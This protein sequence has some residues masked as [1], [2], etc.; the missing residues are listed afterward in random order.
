[1]TLKLRELP[2]HAAPPVL[3]FFN[4]NSTLTHAPNSSPAASHGYRYPDPALALGVGDTSLWRATLYRLQW[5]YLKPWIQEHVMSQT[6]AVTNKEWK[7]V[8]AAALPS[9]GEGTFTA[10][11]RLKIL[12]RLVPNIDDLNSLIVPLPTEDASNLPAPTREETW[13]MSWELS[14]LNF[15]MDLYVLDQKLCLPPPS[16]PTSTKGEQ[17]AE[18]MQWQV[19]RRNAVLSCF[20]EPTFFPVSPLKARYGLASENR[21][22]RE[23]Y[24]R[25]FWNVM[26]LWPNPKPRDWQQGIDGNLSDADFVRWERSAVVQYFCQT[27]LDTFHRP[28]ILPRTLSNAFVEQL[29]TSGRY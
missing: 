10:Q 6:Q 23:P 22:E 17:D 3:A 15:R 20:L 9:S 4:A 27:F 5:E 8:L 21:A 25:A 12:K 24:T 2:D 18:K 13:L 1:V 19:S 26:N 14:E 11:A 16:K 28:A 29:S 7:L